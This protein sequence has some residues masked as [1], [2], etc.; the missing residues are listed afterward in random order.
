MTSLSLSYSD[1]TFLH[2]T[3]SYDY[4]FE[5]NWIQEITVIVTDFIS[6]KID[7][8]KYLSYTV[9]VWLIE[10]IYFISTDIIIKQLNDYNIE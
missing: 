6:L 2:I 8:S 3:T 4:I 9:T 5:T 1:F 10:Y 7:N